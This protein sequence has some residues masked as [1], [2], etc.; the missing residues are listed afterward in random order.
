MLMRR[1]TGRR[2]IERLA[3]ARV[4][5]LATLAAFAATCVLIEITP[6]PNMAYLAALSLSRGWRVGVAAVAGVALGLAVYGLVAALGL[7]A[8]IDHS[9]ILYE[10]L[11]WAGVAY[12]LW[13]AWEAWSS[14]EET[15]PDAADGRHG[16]LQSAFRRGLITN[17]LNPKAGIFYVAM[18]PAFVTA[19]SDHVLAQTLV[20]SA[21]FVVIATSIH[22][23]IVVL[24][25][26]LHGL[27]TDPARRRTVR[28]ILALVLAGIAIW[29]AWSTA[30]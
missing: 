23:T 7:A 20:L 19:G 18:V 10:V 29:F 24:A 27:L 3:A 21:V 12:L 5:P 14:D 30:R 16:E 22:L 13:L 28:R 1:T 11:R 17:L 25:S 26:R 4:I 15:G 2:R 6:G 8:I 9:L